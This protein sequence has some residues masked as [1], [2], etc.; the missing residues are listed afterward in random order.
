MAL[1]K[2]SNHHQKGL[3][4]AETGKYQEALACIQEHLCGGNGEIS[5]ASYTGVVTPVDW[6]E[7][8]W[9]NLKKQYEQR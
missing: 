3:E 5:I 9:M 2:K 1:K 7:T 6:T 4:L 8:K